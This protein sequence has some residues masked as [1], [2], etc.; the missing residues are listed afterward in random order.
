MLVLSKLP[1]GSPPSAWAVGAAATTQPT[2]STTARAR[3]AFMIGFNA[4][5][6]RSVDRQPLLRRVLLQLVELGLHCVPREH[7]VFGDEDT[8]TVGFH[9]PSRPLEEQD[10]DDGPQEEAATELHDD[11]RALLVRDR[12]DVAEPI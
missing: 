10:E 6:T 2:A 3:R 9:V 1:I 4:P 8:L 5:P 7:V 11:A 12:V